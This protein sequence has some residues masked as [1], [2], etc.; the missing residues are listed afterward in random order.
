MQL[1]DILLLR[2]GSQISTN[3]GTAQK[4]GDGGNI[5]LNS[6][7]IVA[8][9]QE[10]SDIT[11]NA[12]TGAGGNIQIN[13]S[14]IF[15]IQSRPQLTDLSSIT[16]SSTLGV[17]G[18]VNISTLNTDALQNSLTQLPE[19]IID[20]NALIAN[21]CIVRGKNQSAGTFLI[22]GNGGLPQRPGD[23]S[24]SLYP[25]RTIR[26]VPS[27]GKTAKSATSTSDRRAQKIST[28]IVEPQGVYRL[29]NG[30]LV[31]SREC[32]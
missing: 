1:G 22:T 4:G 6:Q 21:S 8:V 24:V 13:S 19:N 20:T 11:A 28:P 15:G 3:A 31:L 25:T 9:P 2:R 27:V 16:A 7:F 17:A 5:N 32:P 10:N 14:A 12:Y 18:A 23:A 26:S 30:H 29:A